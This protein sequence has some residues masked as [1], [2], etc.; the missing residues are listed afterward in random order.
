M[1]RDRFRSAGRQRET[2]PQR[3]MR[4]TLAAQTLR[5]TTVEYLTTTFALA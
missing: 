4:P 5:D 3:V 1:E 2:G